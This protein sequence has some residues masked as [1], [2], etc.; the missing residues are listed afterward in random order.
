[1]LAANTAIAARQQ[2]LQDVEAMQKAAGDA[3]RKDSTKIINSNK[4]WGF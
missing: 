2:A 1:M 3:L 4:S